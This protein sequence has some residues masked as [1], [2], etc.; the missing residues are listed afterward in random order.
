MNTCLDLRPPNGKDHVLMM[1]A[2]TSPV[3]L[4]DYMQKISVVGVD[5][6]TARVAAAFFNDNFK[7][8]NSRKVVIEQQ[9]SLTKTYNVLYRTIIVNGKCPNVPF[10]CSYC[11]SVLCTVLLLSR[12]WLKAKLQHRQA[13]L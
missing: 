5:G 9:D 7:L 13:V 6:I 2:S 10:S 11:D 3:S 4:V 1:A 12:L 8:F